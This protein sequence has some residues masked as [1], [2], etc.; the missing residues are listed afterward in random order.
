MLEPYTIDTHTQPGG[1][2]SGLRVQ[3]GDN[4]I[5]DIYVEETDNYKGE[6]R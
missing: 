3:Y 1:C 5:H 6:L 2:G 4:R